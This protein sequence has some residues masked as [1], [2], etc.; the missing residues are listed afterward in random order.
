MRTREK[1]AVLRMTS[2]PVL[3]TLALL[4]LLVVGSIAVTATRV[5]GGLAGSGGN[6]DAA[7]VEP[8]RSGAAIAFG[9]DVA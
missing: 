3:V 9:V 5:A 8:A 7:V 2:M 4:L 6:P 1:T